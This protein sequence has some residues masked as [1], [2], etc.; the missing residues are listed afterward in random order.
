M[1]L[2]CTKMFLESDRKQQPR[3]ISFFICS[4]PMGCFVMPCDTV[5][6]IRRADI[7]FLLFQAR[8]NRTK[9]ARLQR[10]GKVSG[11]EDG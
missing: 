4:T 8:E 2:A 6:K 7:M 5:D 1:T 11:T 9:D 3:V 10:L